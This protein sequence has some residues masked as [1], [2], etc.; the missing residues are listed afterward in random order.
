MAHINSAEITILVSAFTFGILSSLHCVSM[1]GPLVGQTSSS[2][3]GH[4]FYQIGR[5]I[6]YQ[7][8]GFSLYILSSNLF[9]SISRSLQEYS[10]YLLIA[11]YLYVGIKIW[12]KKADSS[13]A[14]TF[15]SNQYRKYFK[16]ILRVK[17][18]S[19]VPFLMG[20]ISALLPCGLLHTFLLGVL[21]IKN[22]AIVF[23]YIS[24]FW[25]STS[26]ALV[27]INI[28]LR[29]IK[30]KFNVNSQKVLGGFYVLMA[31]YLIY[32]RYSNL[33]PNTSCH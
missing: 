9:N 8:L 27:G 23:L 12:L 11:L 22:P 21:P 16:K 5:L 6:S 2:L 15:F 7:T 20:L 26:P 17:N 29:K 33:L 3:K 1:C 18:K 4:F 13:I 14:N 32:I 28:T 25:L 19:I 24:S 30:T 10:F 31:G